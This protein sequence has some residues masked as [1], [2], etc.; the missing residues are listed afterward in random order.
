MSLQL[1]C[2]SC[3]YLNWRQPVPQFYLAALSHAEV[4]ELIDSDLS[5]AVSHQDTVCVWGKQQGL[6]LHTRG[7]RHHNDW[8]QAEGR[9]SLCVS[10]QRE[11]KR[12]RLR[13]TDNKHRR[14]HMLEC[15]SQ[16][17]SCP[18]LTT[19]NTVAHFGDHLRSYTALWVEVK[20]NTGWKWSRFHSW[21]VQSEEQL[22]N[23]SWL[24][25]DHV[26]QF[27]GHWEGRRLLSPMEKHTLTTVTSAE[28]G[29]RVGICAKVE[30]VG[31]NDQ[32]GPK[33]RQKRWEEKHRTAHWSHHLHYET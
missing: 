17:S 31:E 15:R 10:R 28:R 4:L 19:P 6:H 12:A 20:P 33:D 9:K 27:T 29:Y 14:T 30:T 13:E 32:G 2:T 7:S 18:S 8:V 21:M 24:R 3:I 26:T 11:T 16:I 25:G 22:R 5:I 23:A 1:P